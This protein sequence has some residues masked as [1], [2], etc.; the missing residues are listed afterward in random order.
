MTCIVLATP[1][2][3]NSSSKSEI[4]NA[5]NS[6]FNDVSGGLGDALDMVDKIETTTSKITDI[7][8][9]IT[10]SLS[11]LLEDNLGSFIETALDGVKIFFLA[12]MGPLAALAQFDAFSLAAANPVNKLFDAFGCLGSTVKKALGNTIRNMLKNAITNGIVNPIACAV[13]QFIGNITAKIVGV[14]DSIIGPLLNPINNLFSI[15]GRGFG[16]VKNFLGGSIDIISKIQ[17]LI[18]C[19]DDDFNKVCPPQNEYCL[20][21]SSSKPPGD[22]ATQNSFT[23]ALDQANKWLEEK[24]EDIETYGLFGE[25]RDADGN[26]IDSNYGS[27][28]DIEC[29]GG[30]VLDCGLPR[31]EFFGGDGQGA[32]G[33]LILGNFIEELASEIDELGDPELEDTIP[34]VKRTASIIGVDITYPGE[35][36]TQEPFVSFVDNC[37]QGYGAYGRAVIDKDPNSP[38]YGQVTDVIIISEGENYPAGESRGVFVDKILVENGG[39]GYTLEDEIPDFEICGVDENGSIT[40][41]CTNDKEYFITPPMNIRSERGR[42]AILTPVMTTRRRPSDSITVIDCITP[43]GNIVGYVNG[44][45]YNGPFHVMP[46]GQ[47]MTGVEHSDADSI[48]YNTPQESLRTGRTL[49]RSTG[50]QLRPIQDLIKESEASQ[51]TESAD[52]YTDPVD[53]SMSDD[54]DTTPPPSTPPS[55]PPPSSPPSSGGGGYGGGY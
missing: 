26:V 28:D 11:T 2:K 55:T 6:F 35:G 43:R 52:T 8:G 49:N 32:A 14:M 16:T 33:D 10:T 7:V 18:N 17:G 34:L 4:T 21:K 50:I 13:D 5:L 41:V 40:K 30:N 51:T 1:R 3:C 25:N 9:G 54:N 23:R 37:D 47:K 53:D 44:K 29:N 38:T 20:N 45:E 46:N 48:I 12:K 36:Y 22:A 31:L 15:I 42:G 27:S 39:V 19:K 24:T